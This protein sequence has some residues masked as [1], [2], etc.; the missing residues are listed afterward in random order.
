MM[1]KDHV[2]PWKVP[3]QKIHLFISFWKYIFVLKR[4]VLLVDEIARPETAKRWSW[5]FL[6]FC[7]ILYAQLDK[8]NIELYKFKYNAFS[9]LISC[10]PPNHFKRGL[11]LITRPSFHLLWRTGE[12]L[13]IFLVNLKHNNIH[14]S[15]SHRPHHKYTQNG[16]Q[17]LRCKWQHWLIIIPSTIVLGMMRKRRRQVTELNSSNAEQLSFQQQHGRCQGNQ[18]VE[19]N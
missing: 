17:Q 19:T 16:Y 10:F 13:K 7:F 12:F 8:K 6:D 2:M 18:A 1:Y 3:W 5:N 11:W 4:V 14:A 9:D 15:V